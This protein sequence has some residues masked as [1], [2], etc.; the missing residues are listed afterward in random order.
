MDRLGFDVY[1]IWDRGPHGESLGDLS[2]PNVY[3][4][5]ICLE[6]PAPGTKVAPLDFDE[7]VDWQTVDYD[8]NHELLSVVRVWRCRMPRDMPA[9]PR[10]DLEQRLCQELANGENT[11]PYTN[12]E[13]EQV[14]GVD[15]GGEAGD[16][17][18]FQPA[19]TT[20]PT[21]ALQRGTASGSAASS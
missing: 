4:G 12:E 14:A 6:E 17:A 9:K 19:V 5:K 8:T 13:L 18:A 7:T 16:R 15:C 11:G 3:G 10:D 20:P 21:V 2:G 1:A